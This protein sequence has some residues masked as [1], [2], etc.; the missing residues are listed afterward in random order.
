MG[1]VVAGVG[2][3]RENVIH[4]HVGRVGSVHVDLD[5]A[6]DVVLQCL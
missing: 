3:S 1:E 2:C 4:N 5:L 6:Y